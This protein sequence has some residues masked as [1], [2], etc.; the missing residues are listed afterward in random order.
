MPETAALDII[1]CNHDQRSYIFRSPKAYV[2]LHYVYMYLLQSDAAIFPVGLVHVKYDQPGRSKHTSP[3][4]VEIEG[5]NT[6]CTRHICVSDEMKRCARKIII[7]IIIIN[8]ISIVQCCCCC[9]HDNDNNDDNTQQHTTTHNN[10]QPASTTCTYL[11]YQ[12]YFPTPN[13]Q[14][15][16]PPSQHRTI[17]SRSHRSGSYCSNK[18]IRPYTVDHKLFTTLFHNK[19]MMIMMMNEPLITPHLFLLLLLNTTHLVLSSSLRRAL[20]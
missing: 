8:I 5:T 11:H 15:C 1:L 2:F 10:T 16:A 17:P 3:S 6:T 13:T 9:C 14:H 20:G 7:I 12:S 4:I 19:T 18:W